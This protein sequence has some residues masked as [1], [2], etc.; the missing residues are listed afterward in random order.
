LSA[1]LARTIALIEMVARVE[2]GIAATLRARAAQDE[3]EAAQIGE[4]SDR[5]AEAAA[6]RSAHLQQL[7]R[8][9]AEHA[10]VVALHRSLAHA[11]RLLADLAS[12]EED[13]ANTLTRLAG[14]S[15]PPYLP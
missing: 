14:F 12:T 13:I 1:D 7:A 11:G 10:D 4:G 15:V 8:R 9:W 6:E 3:G 2:T 5:G